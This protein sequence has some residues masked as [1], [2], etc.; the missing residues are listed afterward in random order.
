MKRKW[1]VRLGTPLLALALV[2]AC[3]TTNDQNDDT[4]QDTNNPGDEKP[5]DENI[6]HNEPDRG[7]PEDER[8]DRRNE[9]P[10]EKPPNDSKYDNMINGDKSHTTQ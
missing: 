2:S 5:H 8:D 10:E 3:S 1:M 9:N 4:P 6:N 7:A